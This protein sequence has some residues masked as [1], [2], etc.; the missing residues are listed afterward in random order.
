MKKSLIFASIACAGACA[1][2]AEYGQWFTAIGASASATNAM[3][4]SNGTWVFNVTNGTL[5]VPSL[6]K[7]NMRVYVC[8]AAGFT[9]IDGKIGGT[10]TYLK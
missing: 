3:N 8:C 5:S 10:G 9:G 7:G 2:H 1:L 6:G 4:E